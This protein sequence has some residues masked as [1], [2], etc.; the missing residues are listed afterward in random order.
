MD[1]WFRLSPEKNPKLVQAIFIVDDLQ[2]Q[3]EE[4]LQAF[5]MPFEIKVDFYFT[6][7][8]HKRQEESNEMR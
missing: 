8:S 4:F 3:F 5:I 6:A 7:K 1:N 2:S